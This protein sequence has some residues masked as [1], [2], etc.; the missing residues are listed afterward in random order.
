M[1]V[2]F[3]NSKWKVGIWFGIPI[4]IDIAFVVLVAMCVL[5]TGS[6]FGGVLF[7]AMVAFSIVAHEL[8]HSLTARV[9][10]YPTMSITLSALGGCA[11]LER[12]PKVWWQEMLVAVAGPLVS[13]ILGTLGLLVVQVASIDVLAR[14]ASLN[15]G[16]AIF[17]LLPGFPMDG[18]RV[19]RSFLSWQLRN[20]SK[21]TWW[22]MTVGRWMA[23]IF[24]FLGFMSIISGTPNGIMLILIAWFIW[25][26]G[27]QEYLASL[28]GH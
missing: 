28:Y 25:K 1:S 21:A 23:V 3:N 26:A 16:L 19:L 8:G 15:I 10:G 20:R 13:V 5:S 12:L 17:N 24:G 11:A 4:Y 14:F 2:G 27:E 22:A 6:F 9:F 7:A 18:G